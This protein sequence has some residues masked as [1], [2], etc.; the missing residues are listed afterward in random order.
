MGPN[1]GEIR[2]YFSTTSS[3]IDENTNLL[4]NSSK[5][6]LVPVTIMNGA[7]VRLTVHNLT[8]GEDTGYYWCQAYVSDSSQILSESSAFLLRDQT[9]YLD[10]PCP[11]IF[12][13]GNTKCAT[14]MEVPT[15]SPT[16]LVSTPTEQSTT[17]TPPRN[18]SQS[19]ELILYSVLGLVGFLILICV[20]LA[21]VIL[22]LCRKRCQRIGLEGKSSV[23]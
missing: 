19:S 10:F 17:V 13:N 9:S 18:P 20:S 7:G 4:T 2:W 6:T 23:C 12:R 14:L 5:Y 21:V 22:I 1:V 15:E 3:T 16:D 8:E 11:G